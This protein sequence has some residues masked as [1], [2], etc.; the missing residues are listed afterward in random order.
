MV[1]EAAGCASR[2]T[3]YASLSQKGPLKARLNFKKRIEARIERYGQQLL[4]DVA[5]SI[6]VEAAAGAIHVKSDD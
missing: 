2:R 3:L 1:L 6:G 4:P 5:Q